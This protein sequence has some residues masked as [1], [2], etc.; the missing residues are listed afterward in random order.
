LG[1]RAVWY[2]RVAL[3]IA[4]LCMISGGLLSDAA[5]IAISAAA[6]VVQRVLRPTG[7]P[8]VAVKGA[9]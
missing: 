7:I 5:G 3:I 9:D 2:L 4:A 6:V 8:S 1:A